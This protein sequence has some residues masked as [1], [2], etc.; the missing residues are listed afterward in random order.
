MMPAMMH[1]PGTNI[2]QTS[3]SPIGGINAAMVCSTS[4]ASGTSGQ[5]E[6]FRVVK[7]AVRIWVVSQY[8]GDLEL[9]IRGPSGRE[10]KVLRPRT[11]D[12]AQ[13]AFL[14]LRVMSHAFWGEILYDRDREDNNWGISVRRAHSPGVVFAYQMIFLGYHER[15]TP[16]VR[17]RHPA[18]GSSSNEFLPESLVH[19]RLR[20]FSRSGMAER[21]C[22]ASGNSV[23]TQGI[24]PDSTENDMYSSHILRSQKGKKMCSALSKQKQQKHVFW[25][26]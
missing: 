12:V 6:F 4:A 16:R 2:L 18:G 14:G 20:S 19:A 21:Q 11:T 15:T 5:M 1:V 22:S 10:I 9:F 17:Q 26:M 7:V 25:T 24:P 8:R 23:N 13:E 3:A